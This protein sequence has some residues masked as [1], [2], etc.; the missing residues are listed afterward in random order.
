MYLFIYLFIYNYIQI[1][2]HKIIYRYALSKPMTNIDI[3]SQDQQI[4]FFPM[5]LLAA[6]SA[7]NSFCLASRDKGFLP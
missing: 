7:H 1:Y 4:C 6:S 3:L 2:I 5:L